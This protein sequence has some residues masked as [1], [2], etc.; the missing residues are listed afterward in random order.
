MKEKMQGDEMP[1]KARNK[2]SE[3]I[4]HIICRSISELLLFR[5]NE[6]KNRYL[7]LMKRFS[8]LY[9]CSVYGYC[10]MNNH[11][12]IHLDPRGYDISKIMHS[13]NTSYV[14]YYNK[15]YK[16]H[17]HLFQERFHSSILDSDC[18]NLAVSAYIH[19]N[20]KDIEGYSGREEEYQ[21][22]SYGIYLQLFEDKFNLIDRSF[23]ESLIGRGGNHSFIDKYRIFVNDQLGKEITKEDKDNLNSEVENVYISGRQIVLRE[24]APSSILLYLSNKLKL[25][26]NEMTAQQYH[27]KSNKNRAFLVYVLR[28]LCGMSCRQICEIVFNITISGCSRLCFKGYE[29]I[30]KEDLVYGSIFNELFCY[31]ASYTL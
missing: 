30:R 13:M 12:H 23:I 16:R 24:S 25:P 21:Y 10:L 15:K 17:G 6:D 26:L 19:N 3:A 22:S 9:K 14:L 4:Y 18:Y 2:N 20:S 11:L 5:D 8:E 31:G 1:R 28:V 7:K 27:R 29:L